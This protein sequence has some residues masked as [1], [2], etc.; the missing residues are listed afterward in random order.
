MQKKYKGMDTIRLSSGR[1]DFR[2]SA[3]L[4]Q[5]FHVENTRRD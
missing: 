4:Y 2:N 1:V 3:G 5:L